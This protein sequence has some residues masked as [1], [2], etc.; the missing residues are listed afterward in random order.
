MPQLQPII[1]RPCFQ[2]DLEQVQLIYG[3]HVLTGTG[4]FEL[5]P[6]NLAEITDR[7]SRVVEKRWPYFV[8]SPPHDLSRVLGFA[9]A[10][11]YRDRAAYAHTFEVSVYAAPTSLRQG[12]GG[13]LLN[14]VLSALKDDGA[15]E[16][17]AFIGDSH[18]AASIGLHAKLGFKYVGKLANVGTKFGRWLDVVIM[19][20]SLIE[21]DPAES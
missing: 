1:I 4:T 12:A 14:E 13:L 5:A 21:G 11:Q 16:A 2:Q 19:Q 3:H 9:Y 18:N 7:W 6:P 17:L 10:A 8:A 15:R 20:R